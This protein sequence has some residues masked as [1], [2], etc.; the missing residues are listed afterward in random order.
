MWNRGGIKTKKLVI[1]IIFILIWLSGFFIKQWWLSTI[2]L[3]ITIAVIL[4]E[5]KKINS[6]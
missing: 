3:L 2:G 6:R 1:L 5:K 4:N